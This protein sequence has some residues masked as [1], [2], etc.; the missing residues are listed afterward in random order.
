MDAA[1]KFKIITE[2]QR[3]G[4]S[5][6][7][8][9]YNISRTLYYRWLK[10]YKTLGIKGLEPVVKQFVPVN[11]SSPEIIA[12]TLNI[13]K[14][15]PALGPRE[16]KYRLEAM[17]YKISESAVYNIMKRHLL[18]KKA[19]RLDYARRRVK[20]T[21]SPL[22]SFAHLSSGECWLFWS[23]YY[24]HFKGLGDLYEYSIMDYKSRI[25]C[26]RLY[27]QL[28]FTNFV[29]LL[30]AVAIPVGQSLGF[31]TK[32]LCFLDQ[33]QVK[34]NQIDSWLEE[35]RLLF[36]NAGL[37][38][39]VHLSHSLESHNDFDALRKNYTHQCLSLLMPLVHSGVS[40]NLIKRAL[41]KQVRI[42]NISEPI[43][44][45]NGLCSPVEYHIQSTNTKMIL[46]LWAYLDRDY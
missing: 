41:Q 4:I 14:S 12:S 6:T 46:P 2:G 25:V 20:K 33:Y 15:Q 1:E 3:L 9:R 38:V 45:E 5:E 7:C 34:Q 19:Q 42:Y 10:R 16:V 24:G 31:E 39:S 26:T 36:Q 28:S 35:V 32:H 18:T 43:T 13:I 29:D 27:T 17:G 8:N 22:P 37:E 40:I 44:F 30:T 23:T 11:K 21:K